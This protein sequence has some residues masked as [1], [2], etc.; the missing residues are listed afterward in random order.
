VL[1]VAYQYAAKKTQI[2][3]KRFRRE[4]IFPL[5]TYKFE[6]FDVPGP[7]DA[8]AFLEE[9][10]G[11]TGPNAVWDAATAKYVKA[12]DKA[13][14]AKAGAAAAAAAAAAADGDDAKADGAGD[15]DGAGERRD[16]DE[17]AGKVAKK[18][19]SDDE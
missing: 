17:A 16:T 11:Y 2:E 5:K 10:Y 12:P 14:D 19:K 6:G 3:K 13:P 4:W 9:L 15:K 1:C 18:A 7:N 8:W